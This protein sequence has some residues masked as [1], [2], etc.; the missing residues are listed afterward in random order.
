MKVIEFVRESDKDVVKM[1]QVILNEKL[2]EYIQNGRD[3][4]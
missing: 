2:C 1:K 4:F 3:E